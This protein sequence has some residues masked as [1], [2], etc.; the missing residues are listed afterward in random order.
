[1]NCPYCN[2]E[3]KKGVVSGEAVCT[4]AV[5]NAPK[6]IEMHPT[7]RVYLFCIN[8]R[9]MIEYIMKAGSSMDKNM[10]HTG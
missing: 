3:M 6:T 5:L 4:Q 1:M 2:K 10:N 7:N 9:P 8:I